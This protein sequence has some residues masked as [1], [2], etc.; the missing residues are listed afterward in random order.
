MYAHSNWRLRLFDI[1][2][3]ENVCPG[4]TDVWERVLQNRAFTG[5]NAF[6]AKNTDGA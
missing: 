6:V 3:V 4:L 1:F 2:G 5:Y